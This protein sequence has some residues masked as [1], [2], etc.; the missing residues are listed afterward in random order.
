MTATGLVDSGA[1]VSVMP[2]RL[3]L[4]LAAD[5]EAQTTVVRLSGNLAD[6]EARGL[7]VSATV[8]DLSPVRLA[9]AWTQAENVPLILGQVNFFMAFNVCFFRSDGVFEIWPRA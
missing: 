3:G 8:S 5:W 7:I 2:Y 1:D 4:E 9:F 6:H